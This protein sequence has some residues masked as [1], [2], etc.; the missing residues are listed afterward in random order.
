[1]PT[2]SK[3]YMSNYMKTYNANNNEDIVCDICGRK[4]KKYRVYIHRTSQHHQK[5]MAKIKLL[6]NQVCHQ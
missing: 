3:E 5:A 6:L 4:Y 2:N 1:M